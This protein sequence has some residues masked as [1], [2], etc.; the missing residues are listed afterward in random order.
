V[1]GSSGSGPYQSVRGYLVKRKINR[2]E[3]FMPM[4]VVMNVFVNPNKEN[5]QLQQQIAKFT[6]QCLYRG[7]NMNK[8]MW[9]GLAVFV[10]AFATFITF[11]T[12]QQK[13]EYYN[14]TDS[15]TKYSFGGDETK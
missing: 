5:K 11:K 6:E 12:I 13:N 10:F 3:S 7:D 9:I 15:F 8:K 4:N 1:G 2:M 14:L